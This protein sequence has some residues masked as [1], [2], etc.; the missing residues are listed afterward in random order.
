MVSA[1]S[2]QDSLPYRTIP[3]APEA[4]TAGNVAARTIDGLGFRFYWATEGLRPED[5]AYRPSEEARSAAETIHHIYSMVTLVYNL[6]HDEPHK[7]E[8]L[9]FEEERAHAL[10]LLQQ[11][12][13]R[14]R[15]SSPEDMETYRLVHR[16]GV[17]L[18]FWNMLNGPIAD[19]TWHCGQIVSF[20]RASGNPFPSGVSLM[21]GTVEE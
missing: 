5:L 12:S 21:T 19:C 15:A 6:M 7:A 2:P 11:I 9:S 1:Q 18:P 17:D 10:R 3:E 4:Y 20:R 8:E 13:Q 14:L 16:S